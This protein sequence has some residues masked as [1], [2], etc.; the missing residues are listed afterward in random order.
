MTRQIAT[1]TTAEDYITSSLL[2]MADAIDTIMDSGIATETFS[3]RRFNLARLS[4][5][6]CGSPASVKHVAK[7]YAQHRMSAQRKRL[8]DIPAGNISPAQIKSN[9]LDY[10]LWNLIDSHCTPLPDVLPKVHHWLPLCYTKNFAAAGKSTRRHRT[11]IHAAEFDQQGNVTVA[12]DV[13]DTT[14]AHAVQKG[15][16][17]YYPPY[18]E[19]FFGRIETY[20]AMCNDNQM[21]GKRSAYDEVVLFAF[22][23]VQSS[24]NPQVSNTGEPVPFDREG[25]SRIIPSIFEAMNFFETPYI[26]LV[27]VRESLW[28]SPFFPPRTRVTAN[29]VVA[30]S[31]TLTP[32]TAMVVTNREVSEREAG[33]IATANNQSLI[34]YA[35]RT[36]TVLYGIDPF[37]G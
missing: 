18:I 33:E 26:S 19:M 16:K 17:G 28:F 20:Y 15:N 34:A 32:R 11:M 10:I 24:R 22:F 36:G 25:I 21:N 12:N 37:G 13:R 27:S 3:G 4:D 23:V 30:Q 8:L 1:A 29:G 5:R 14:F 35:G 7:V 6:L 31:F 2:K 9:A